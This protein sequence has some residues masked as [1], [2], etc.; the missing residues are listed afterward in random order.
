MHPAMVCRRRCRVKSVLV[1][2]AEARE[3]AMA[4]EGLG[5]G[6]QSRAQSLAAGNVEHRP[7]KAQGHHHLLAGVIIMAVT[8][9]P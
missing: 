2:D 4:G 1:V 3:L 6:R 9:P 7:D 5:R 8:P